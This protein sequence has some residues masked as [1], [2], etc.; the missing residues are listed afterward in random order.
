MKKEIEDRKN[1]EMKL[2]RVSDQEL[3]YRML[4]EQS[5]DAITIVSHDG[6][7]LEANQAF[8]SMMD[9]SRE[10]IMAMDPK[11]FWVSQ[12]DRGIWLEQLMEQGS[13]ID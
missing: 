8:L 6:K 2:I 4:F 9:C 3:R 12:E 11:E 7:F 5:K 13:I 1:T 10:E